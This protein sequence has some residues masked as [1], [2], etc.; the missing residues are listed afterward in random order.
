MCIHGDLQFLDTM[1][2]ELEGLDTRESKQVRRD[3]SKARDEY[4]QGLMN[5]NELAQY[6]IILLNNLELDGDA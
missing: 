4:V 2:I 1:V 5:Y 6:V 3:I